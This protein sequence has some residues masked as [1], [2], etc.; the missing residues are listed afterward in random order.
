MIFKPGGV[1]P[2]SAT[3]HPDLARLPLPGEAIFPRTPSRKPVQIAAM[4]ESEKYYPTVVALCD[5]GT[6]WAY[7]F[8]SKIWSE[9]PPIPQ[10]RNEK[11]YPPK[12]GGEA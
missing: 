8:D 6:M 11:A 12:E 1:V 4:P 10:N 5:D 7:N 9:L 3:I 2:E